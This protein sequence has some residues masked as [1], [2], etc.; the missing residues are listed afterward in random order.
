MA[1]YDDDIFVEGTFYSN[2]AKVQQNALEDYNEGDE[3]TLIYIPIREITYKDNSG[4]GVYY[5]ENNDDVDVPPTFIMCGTF[6]DHLDLGQTYKSDG[7]ITLRQGARQ[8]SINNITKITPVTKHGIIS[9]MRSLDGMRFQA[10]LIY[11]K[12]DDV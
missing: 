2:R 6:T 12:F 5:C 3:V 4:F 9:F 8:L 10:D 7:T 11:D 1:V